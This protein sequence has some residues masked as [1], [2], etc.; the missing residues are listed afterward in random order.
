MV[1]WWCACVCIRVCACACVRA[2]ACVCVCVGGWVCVWVGEGWGGVTLCQHGK[3][4]LDIVGWGES[5]WVGGLVGGGV[6][7]VCVCVRMR[8]CVC[9]CV[10]VCMYVCGGGGVTL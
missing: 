1:V 5:G 6:V 10:C 2:R 9:V 8:V 7:C 3:T 4:Y